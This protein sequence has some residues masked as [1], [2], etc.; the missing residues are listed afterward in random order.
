MEALEHSLV[1]LPENNEFLELDLE[2]HN[3]FADHEL[4]HLDEHVVLGV[5]A[6][7]KLFDLSLKH[8]DVVD[9]DEAELTGVCAGLAHLELQVLDVLVECG[10]LLLVLKVHFSPSGVNFL[11]V[12]CDGRLVGG[13]LSDFVVKLSDSGVHFVVLNTEGFTIKT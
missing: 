3:G 2:F 10:D 8:C 1:I 13:D 11:D 9:E 4:L 7:R 12:G 6:D 5:E